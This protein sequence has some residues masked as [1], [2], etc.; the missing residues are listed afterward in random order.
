MSKTIVFVH[1]AWLT[2]I[3][4]NL[5]RERYEARGYTTLAPPWPLEDVPIEELRSS[6]HPDLGK[7]TITSIVDHYDK[8]IRALPEAPIII[9][10]SFGGLFTQ[11]LLDRGLGAA[12]VGVD[13]GPVFGVIP[14][15]RSFLSAL[16][17]L[18]AWKGWSRVLPMTF[19]QFASN[20]AQTLPPAEMRPAYERYIVPTP[21]RIYFQAAL[22]ISAGINPKNPNRAPL[23]LIAG[24]KDRTVTQSTVEANYRKQRHAPSVTAFK[25]FPRRS[26]F[27]FAEPGWEEVADYAIDWASQNARGALPKGL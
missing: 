2:P 6:P 12:G 4:W 16:P 17:V 19:E 5:W 26:H 7:T 8:L 11:L 15:P 14:R 10:H 22:G 18:T 25:S 3:G 20:F 27:L 13:P 24:E 21:G 9:G 1:G 23:L